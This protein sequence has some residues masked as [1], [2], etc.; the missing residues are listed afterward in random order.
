MLYNINRNAVVADAYHRAAWVLQLNNILLFLIYL[1]FINLP[2]LV[3][4]AS[5]KRLAYLNL[6]NAYC[7]VTV[8]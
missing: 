2:N 4:I 5:A 3:L 1:R 8:A 7:C 6:A